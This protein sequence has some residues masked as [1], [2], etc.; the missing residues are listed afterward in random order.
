[1]CE[2]K[3][4]LW[5]QV[6]MLKIAML[7]V[8]RANKDIDEIQHSF[9]ES[10]IF[11]CLFSLDLRA[12]SE[13]NEISFTLFSIAEFWKITESD[14]KSTVFFAGTVSFLPAPTNSECIFVK[15]ILVFFFPFWFPRASR[16]GKREREKYSSILGMSM[17]DQWAIIG[18][19]RKAW[20]RHLSPIFIYIGSISGRSVMRLWH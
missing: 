14:R 6:R 4:T 12:R 2:I 5:Y 11:S 18:K 20:I 17:R 1:M 3:F 19:I 10:N 13:K 16:S 15:D 8:L 7:Y 9:V